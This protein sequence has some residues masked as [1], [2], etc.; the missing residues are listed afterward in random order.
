[1]CGPMDTTAN[2]PVYNSLKTGSS[3]CSYTHQLL[4]AVIF[5]H[6][7][8][9][10][11]VTTTSNTEA[12]E[13]TATTASHEHLSKKYAKILYKLDWAS[14]W[15]RLHKSIILNF[16]YIL[17]DF[18]LKLECS[19]T[20]PTNVFKRQVCACALKSI[21]NGLHAAGV[22]SHN[23]HVHLIFHIFISP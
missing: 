7:I 17:F 13:M 22:T 3:W 5:N 10:V 9:T 18:P 16:E 21:W 4:C 19:C 15:H 1:M 14:K 20:S 11:S 23:E 12:N 2:P 8:N 6:T